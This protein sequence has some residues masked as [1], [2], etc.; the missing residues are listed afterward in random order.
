MPL[1]I[2]VGS[3]GS[4]LARIQVNE[5]FQEIVRVNSSIVFD[6]IWVTTTGDR[7]L[8]TSLRT[9]EKSDFFTKEIDALLL[10]GGCRIAIHSAKDLSEPLQDGLVMAALTQGVDPSDALVFRKNESLETLPLGARIGTSSVRREE[11]ILKL[12]PDAL[13]VDIRG[14]IEERLSLLDQGIF[15]AVI[16]AEA[17]L[18]RLKLNNRNRFLIP[19][20]AAALQ[21]Q[22]AVIIRKEDD[23]MRALFSTI[24]VRR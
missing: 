12:R 24:D 15:D 8:Q 21:G 20:P 14:T 3:R 6:P 18:I 9:L 1:L 7:D 5:V 2:K 13:C 10:F 22:L 16:M 4:S 17:A 19:G 23:E 11:M